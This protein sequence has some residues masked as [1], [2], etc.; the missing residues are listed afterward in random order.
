MNIH[1]EELCDVTIACDDDKP[2]EAHKINI[3]RLGR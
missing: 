2:I 3:V 1:V